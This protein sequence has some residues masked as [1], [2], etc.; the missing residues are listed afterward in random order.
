[1]NNAIQRL[2]KLRSSVLGTVASFYKEL[3]L[4]GPELY[5]TRALFTAML[6]TLIYFIMRP[7]IGFLVDT[8][9]PRPLSPFAE[10]QKVSTVFFHW[11]VIFLCV[12]FLSLIFL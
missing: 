2:Y 1:M 12:F 7:S 9:L 10:D 3:G 4:L 5:T 8:G 11:S 6:G